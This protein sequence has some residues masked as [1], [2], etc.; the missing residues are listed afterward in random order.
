M[1]I[2]LPIQYT[3]YVFYMALGRNDFHGGKFITRAFG[4]GRPKKLRLFSAQMALASLI[5]I[6]GPNKVLIFRAHP[7]R[8]ALVMDLPAS[9][10]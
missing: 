2:K 6:S 4:R 1:Y 3:V 7:F 5:A 8:M 9:K 10:S